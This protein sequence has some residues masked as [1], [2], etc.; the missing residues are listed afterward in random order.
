MNSRRNGAGFAAAPAPSAAF[1]SQ[2]TDRRR[3]NHQPGGDEL[4]ERAAF[5]AE[6]KR[7]RLDD[8]L[9]FEEQRIVGKR[10]AFHH[11]LR[12]WAAARRMALTMFG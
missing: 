11:Y 8:L 2:H 10:F 4:Y 5:Q 12:A 1:L 7:H 6:I 9:V 3:R